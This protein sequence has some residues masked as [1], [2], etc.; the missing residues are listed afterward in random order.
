MRCI[1]TRDVGR[2]EMLATPFDGLAFLISEITAAWPAHASRAMRRRSRA[3]RARTLPVSVPRAAR[4]ACRRDFF[5]L[6][7]DDSVE[8]VAHVDSCLIRKSQRLNCC[9]KR[10]SSSTFARP[11]RSRS[12]RGR[13]GC[14]P[15]S[16]RRRSPHRARAGVQRDDFTRDAR[17]VV[18]RA[19]Q[20]RARFVGIFHLQRAVRHHLQAEVFRM[21]LVF[22]HLAVAQLADERCRAERYLVHPVLAVHDQHV[23]RPGAASR[24]PGCR[25]GRGGTRPSAGSARRPGWSAG[26]GC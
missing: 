6:D 15:R 8:N 23:L 5:A 25:R 17:L 16:T 21:D 20:H 18:Q 22:V 10:T 3:G 2:H 11:C 7:G 1:R 13:A 4:C 24:A 12:L 9:V 14:R 19:E 26:R